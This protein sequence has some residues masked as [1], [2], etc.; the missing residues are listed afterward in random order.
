MKLYIENIKNK[1]INKNLLTDYKCTINTK[2][3]I[4]SEQGI[5]KLE[6]NEMFMLKPNDVLKETIL[7]DKFIGILDKS[8]F[9]KDEIWFQIPTQ[10][11]LEEINVLTYELRPN[12]LIELVIEEKYNEIKDFYFIIKGK[13]CTLGWKDDVLTFLSTLKLY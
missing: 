13:L 10:H 4:I 9:I 2:K 7:I 1:N 5:I 11:I 6:N 3:I 8:E 12:G